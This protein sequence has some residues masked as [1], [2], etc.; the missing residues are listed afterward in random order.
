M[1]YC[2]TNLK[3]INEITVSKLNI[4]QKY[5]IALQSPEYTEIYN[6]NGI[7]ITNGYN[8]ELALQCDV[9]WKNYQAKINAFL[10]TL[11][12]AEQELERQKID[13]QDW[14]WEWFTKTVKTKD[15]NCYEWFFLQI[16]SIVEAACLITFPKESAL[17]QGEQI[18]Y[19]DFIAVAPWNRYS[20]LE[21]KRHKGL[22]YTVLRESISFLS[23]QYS[24]ATRFALHSLEQAEQFYVQKLKMQHCPNLDK[25]YLKYFELPPQQTLNTSG[26][27]I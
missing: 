12:E 22:G 26:G 14:H 20:P 23:K 8:F 3:I 7:V 5:N 18:F 25:P 6:D 27:M 4:L 11:T 9:S 24:G 10:L 13:D 1:L 16:D 2:K 17:L 19:I 15:N 21:E